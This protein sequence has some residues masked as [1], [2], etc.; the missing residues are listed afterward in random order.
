M[1]TNEILRQRQSL[2][3][4]VKIQMSLNRIN[5][6]YE[7][8][9]G[10]V[11]VAFSG[12][13]DSTVLLNLVRTIYPDVPAVFNNTGVEFPEIRNFIKTIDNV[14]WLKPTKSYEE[15]IN[16]YGYP[17]IS[18]EISKIVYAL[19]NY[20]LSPNYKEQQ[21]KRL[22]NKWQ[23]LLKAPFKIS[24]RCCYYLKKSIAIKYEK[25]SG[26]Y[27]FI[28]ILASEGYIRKQIY[29]KQG[30]NAFDIK[31]PC[32]KPISFWLAKDIWE[33]IRTNKIP[34]S[35]IYDM[36]YKSTGCMY[37]GFGIQFKDGKQR[38]QD[39]MRTHPQAHKYAIT[40]LGMKEVL[41]Y[42]NIP[43]DS[44]QTIIQF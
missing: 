13:K 36:G 3:L 19:R 42:I 43:Y 4:K 5:E 39:L 10:Q 28:G 20:S 15:I 12:G 24:D 21:L 29:L 30:C 11:Y 25:G 37:C 22:G 9:N 27:P 18:K 8:F 6:F 16:Q 33:Y 1:I 41:D 40:K 14:I 31:R 7:H 35:S 44:Y 17:I 23:F 34:Y 32:S 38:F 2:P 26:R